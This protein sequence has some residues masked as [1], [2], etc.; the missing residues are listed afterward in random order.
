M[1]L[2]QDNRMEEA[3]N[4]WLSPA[5]LNGVT[6]LQRGL[7]KV[8]AGEASPDDAEFELG[9]FARERDI[10]EVEQRLGPMR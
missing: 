9:I 6:M 7:E 10:I 1:E 2:L 3:E 4:Y 5:G 8:A